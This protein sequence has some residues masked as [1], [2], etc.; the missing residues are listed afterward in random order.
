MFQETGN[1]RWQVRARLHYRGTGRMPIEV[2]TTHGER[3]DDN[4]E[5]TDDYREARIT[6][7]IGPGDVQDLQFE[8]DFEPQRLIVD[9]DA[10]VLQLH[11]HKAVEDL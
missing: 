5:V 1:G 8:C 3:F 6:V 10:L 4:G 9:P 11:R 2:A 7:I